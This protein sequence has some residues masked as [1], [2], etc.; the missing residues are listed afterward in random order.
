MDVLL[1]FQQRAI[2]RRDHQV[3]FAGSQSLDGKVF[4]RDEHLRPDRQPEF[5]QLDLELSFVTEDDVQQVVERLTAAFSR[6]VFGV[7]PKL[8]LSRLPYPHAT[9]QSVRD[10]PLPPLD[11]PFTLVLV[12]FV[13]FRLFF[14]HLP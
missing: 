13:V 1:I 8:P 7:E 9:D 11:S 6:Y 4:D 10:L 12:V 2:Q 3:L 5:P 14:E